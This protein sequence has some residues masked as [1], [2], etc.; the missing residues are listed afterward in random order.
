VKEGVKES[1][2]SHQVS[3]ALA[4]QRLCVGKSVSQLCRAVIGGA[5]L[6]TTSLHQ[7]PPPPPP[8]QQTAIEQFYT[9][10]PPSKPFRRLLC[11]E[12]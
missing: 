11:T 6:Q 5:V 8:Q 3:S 9:L 10:A 4:A 2:K 7:E 1:C 12:R